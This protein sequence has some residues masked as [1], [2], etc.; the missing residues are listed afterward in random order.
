[1]DRTPG[2]DLLELAES[3]ARG[4]RSLSDAERRA[5]SA[6]A[7][8]ELRELV[9]AIGAVGRHAQAWTAT[10]RPAPDAG[11]P[12][13]RPGADGRPVDE[14]IVRVVPAAR[15]S[16][17]RRQSTRSTGPRILL[18]AATVAVLAGGLALAGSSLLSPRPSI[19][20]SPNPSGVAV[21]SPGPSPSATES[22]QPGP[23]ASLQP[24]PTSSAPAPSPSPIAAGI[25]AIST[26]ALTGSPG[27]AV[28]RFAAP[29]RI[30][31]LAWRSGGQDSSLLEFDTWADPSAQS[32]IQRSVVVSP[33]GSYVAVAETKSDGSG[34]VRVFASSGSTA[35]G[36]LVWTD[37]RAAGMPSL[38]WSPAGN[39]LAVG[40][41]PAPWLVVQ[42]SPTGAASATTYNLS[43]GLALALLGFNADGTVLYGYES[44]GEAAPWQKPYML[45][46]HTGTV[47]PIT[48]YPD[49]ATGGAAANTTTPLGLVDPQTGGV[50]DP[51]GLSG[52]DATW[53]I[54][55]AGTK[56][57]L[58]VPVS[59]PTGGT[60]LLW[61]GGGAIAS[62][63]VRSA[64]PGSASVGSIDRPGPGATPRTVRTLPAG[65]GLAVLRGARDGYALV[66]LAASRSDTAAADSELVLVDLAT[67]QADAFA[68][69]GD[70]ALSLHVAGFVR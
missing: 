57:A 28:W 34:R 19:A 51:G 24:S 55:R 11:A 18:V 39:E 37:A 48:A 42:L 13:S 7:A 44:S 35:G 54:R 61:S 41:V 40:Y 31:V 50:L 59:T 60:A 58:G 6:A 16:L 56:T 64:S 1:M 52:L 67:G 49:A 43:N 63:T 14:P 20:P 21:G 23:S 53:S 69:A 38:A 36:R 2:P 68:V 10:T 4:E 15:P 62:L 29:T 27:V 46:L 22:G 45:S 30:Q 47:G 9:G 3:V 12:A 66:G 33:D 65:T 25:P 5:G 26:I 17:R 32:P 70:P 8:A